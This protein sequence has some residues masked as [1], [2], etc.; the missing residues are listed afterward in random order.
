MVV[1]VVVR[2]WTRRVLGISEQRGFGD[3]PLVC[4]EEKNVG[5]GRV[6]LV[7]FSRM[8]RLLLDRLDLQGVKLLIE[9]LKIRQWHYSII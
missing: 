2:T 8:N 6:H 3:V 1:F 4:G 9:H 7:G 5:A